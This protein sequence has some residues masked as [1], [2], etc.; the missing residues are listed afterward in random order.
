FYEASLGRFTSS[1]EHAEGVLD[2]LPLEVTTDRLG[3]WLPLDAALYA[4][5]LGPD[6][7]EGEMAEHGMGVAFPH[8][9]RD[10][11]APFAA[12]PFT[13]AATDHLMELAHGLAE[14]LELGKDA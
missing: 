13:P 9:P 14:R 3:P 6:D 4:E 10:T 5:R 2:G 7:A 11:R 8:L 12:Y 1:W